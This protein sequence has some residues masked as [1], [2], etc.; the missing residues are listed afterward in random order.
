MRN[1]DRQFRRRQAAAGRM[2][3]RQFGGIRQLFE[4]ARDDMIGFQAGDQGGVAL[5][6][7]GFR[8]A[9]LFARQQVCLLGIVTQDQRLDLGRDAGQNLIALHHRQ[10][11][12]I[13]FGIEPDL[14]VD[15]VVRAI[16]AGRIVDRVGKDTAAGEREFDAA[17]L[18]RA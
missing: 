17:R 13:D 11:A 18:R 14:D 8:L 3:A 7:C 16:D 4:R 15:F 2:P 5:L 9:L 12:G 10:G 1:H 6:R